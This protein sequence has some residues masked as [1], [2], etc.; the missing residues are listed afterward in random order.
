MARQNNFSIIDKFGRS[1]E[2]TTDLG[3]ALRVAELDWVAKEAPVQY[4]IDNGDIRR[5]DNLR[6]LYRSDNGE[7]LGCVGNKYRALQNDEAFAMAEA[8]LGEMH[9]L[10]GG[11]FGSQTTVTL[12]AADTE[13][14]GDTIK[15]FVTFR[16][17]FDGSSKVQFA[18]IPVRQVCEN[19]LCVQIPKLKRVFEI[20]H[21]GDVGKKYQELF[22]MNAIGD[23][24]EEFK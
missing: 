14:E 6:V 5:N 10:R 1:I 17:S 3:E 19:G 24:T 8:L 22:V 15:N 7:Y 23:G 4:T 12:R 13:I 11:Q 9:F 18:W 21:L 2:G 16:N 20:P